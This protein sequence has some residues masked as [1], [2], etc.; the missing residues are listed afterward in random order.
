MAV[1]ARIEK[2]L[3]VTIGL[4]HGGRKPDDRPRRLAHVNCRA[5]LEHCDAAAALRDHILNHARNDAAHDLMHAPRGFEAG[6]L[7]I[8]VRQ[9]A[10]DQWDGRNVLKREQIR[11]QAVVDVKGVVG[12]VVDRAATCASALA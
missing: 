4:V 6:M 2:T 9:N 5:R 1:H 11:A 8:D 10:V 12:D 7:A 3:D